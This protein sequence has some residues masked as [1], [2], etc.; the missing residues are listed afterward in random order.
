MG[1]EPGIGRTRGSGGYRRCCPPPPRCSPGKFCG[2]LPGLAVRVA[3]RGSAPAGLPSPG[4]RAAA[5]A[6][7]SAPFHRHSGRELLGTNPGHRPCPVPLPRHTGGPQPRPLALCIVSSFLT[8]FLAHFRLPGPFPE[9][10][11]RVWREEDV[12]GGWVAAQLQSP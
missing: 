8:P 1:K 2:L 12:L 6:G 3:V 5:P 9:V 11:S 7:S 10:C 4:R